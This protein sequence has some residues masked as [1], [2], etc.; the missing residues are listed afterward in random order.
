M[1]P[2]EKIIQ[3]LKEKKDLTEFTAQADSLLD[4]ITIKELLNKDTSSWNEQWH[5]TLST[6]KCCSHNSA[7]QLLLLCKTILK[8][9]TE[10]DILSH[11]Y[12]SLQCAD[13]LST[14]E[15]KMKA[16]ALLKYIKEE[17]LLKLIN[18]KS[19]DLSSTNTL[20]LF[21]LSAYPTSP[22]LLSSSL[23]S[24]FSE[25]HSNNIQWANDNLEPSNNPIDI[26]LTQDRLLNTF[27][28]L[29][30]ARDSSTLSYAIKAKAITAHTIQIIEDSTQIFSLLKLLP[31]QEQSF[32][33][34]YISLVY[35]FS[36]FVLKFISKHDRKT[37]EN[38]ISDIKT[39]LTHLGDKECT[40]DITFQPIITP[41]TLSKEDHQPIC[42]HPLLTT[43][44][45][46][47]HR[48]HTTKDT[49]SKLNTQPANCQPLEIY[50]PK[51]EEYQTENC[52]DR[53]SGLITAFWSTSKK[54]AD[55][56]ASP[57]KA[58]HPLSTEQG[59]TTP[60]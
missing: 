58:K 54:T 29:I 23:E 30:E 49:L 45:K 12:N 9:P 18:D 44:K 5:Q 11:V 22:R 42:T 38:F 25:I 13:G 27:I 35:I 40:E 57:K 33:S 16:K 4:K 52:C 50:N 28:P 10:D 41:T 31:K 19:K 39:Q 56:R 53:I 36:G 17:T 8:T 14:P 51:K 2:S 26:S 48:R 3:L 20:E 55:R 60:N 46:T 59:L 6:Y 24:V 15:K 47:V 37:L 32:K 1:R 34:L 21:Y 43:S 7:K